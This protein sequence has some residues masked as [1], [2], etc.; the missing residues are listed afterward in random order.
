MTKLLIVFQKP[1]QCRLIFVL[2]GTL[3][4]G[5]LEM[6][7]IG[8]IP[9]FVGIMIDPGWLLATVSLSERL[10][11]LHEGHEATLLVAAGSMLA[12]AFGLK[13]LLVLALVYRETH[14]VQTIGASISNRLFHGYMH[15]SYHLHVQRNPAEVVRN[16]TE[17]TSHAMDFVRAGL[18]LTREALVLALVFLLMLVVE[19]VLSFT[20]LCIFAGASV[21]FY[22]AL[23]HVLIQHGWLWGHHWARRVQIITQTLG[24]IKD[25]KLLGRESYFLNLFRAET[26]GL[27]R[28]E[29]FQEVTSLLPRYLLEA[30]AIWAAVLIAVIFLLSQ[31]PIGSLAP[32]LVLYA[33]AAARVLPAL[34]TIN[35]SL[36]ELR[37]RR[38]ALELVCAELQALETAT[39]VERP[40]GVKHTIRAKRRGTIS[41]ENVR[42][43]H[44]G[45]ISEALQGVSLTVQPGTIVGIVGPSGAG[46]STLIDL[47]LGL[48][49]PSEGRVLVDGAD[50]HED[51][52]TWQRRIGYVP[53]NIYLI[54]DTIRRNIAFGLPDNEIDERAVARALRAA[55]LES[56]VSTLPLGIETTV[57][58][59]GIRLSGGQR[60]RLAIARALY[61][62]PSILVMDEAT[63]A[64]D[65]ETESEI[66]A[67][68]RLLSAGKTVIVAAHRPSTVDSCDHLIR[69]D[70]GRIVSEFQALI[71]G[72]LS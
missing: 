28:Q 12:G 46:K 63:N 1:D 24:A 67:D 56:F 45:A 55:R 39:H 64:L 38:P 14:F 15:S 25:V 65:P 47:I 30:L 54:D 57:G 59:E 3:V 4:T 41:L 34:S 19:P 31:R 37:Y 68:L 13:T 11:W 70:S 21:A 61:H 50:V 20:L 29:T 53:Q 44:P 22:S 40:D 36:L 43:R 49:L 51:L 66:M 26:T 23:R 35:S 7:G 48:H 2:F 18:R 6:I 5:V 71:A 32:V 60:Q 33:M 8:T 62:D 10:S 69:L 72:Q 42:Y 52:P 16:L 58:H 17:E 27:H 9:V